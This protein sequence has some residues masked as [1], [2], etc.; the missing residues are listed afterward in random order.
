MSNKKCLTCVGLAFLVTFMYFQVVRDKQDDLDGWTENENVNAPALN[1]L[2][3]D[4]Y[5][6]MEVK[7]HFKKTR[8]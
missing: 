8:L 4:T 7:Y 2:H 1:Q 5:N 3:D 6:Y